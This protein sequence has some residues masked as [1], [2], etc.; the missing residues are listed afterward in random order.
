M[1]PDLVD[2]DRFAHD[3]FARL[4]AEAPTARSNEHTGMRHM[5]VRV[6]KGPACTG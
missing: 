3:V 2:L 4:R 6:T 5:P 1:N